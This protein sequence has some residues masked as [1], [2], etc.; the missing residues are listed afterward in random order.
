MRTGA[1][2]HKSQSNHPKRPNLVSFLKIA[3]SKKL[4]MELNRKALANFLFLAIKFKVW[5]HG[6]LLGYQIHISLVMVP[7]S[8]K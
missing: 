8:H 3:K 7:R 4:F 6:W 2:L 5:K 1:Y